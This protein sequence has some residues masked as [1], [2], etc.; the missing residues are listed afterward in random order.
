MFGWECEAA[1][2]SPAKKKS[3]FLM[4]QSRISMYSNL[5][6]SERAEACEGDAGQ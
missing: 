5:K 1:Q 2:N 4:A 6:R 3:P